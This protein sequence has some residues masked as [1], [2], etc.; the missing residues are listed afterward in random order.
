MRDSFSESSFKFSDF[1]ILNL[2][3]FFQNFLYL[4]KG[5]SLNYQSLNVLLSLA[6]LIL[7][8][9]NVVLQLYDFNVS[10]TFCPSSSDCPELHTL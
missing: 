5:S 9:A 7:Q 2:Y 1:F 6:E 10:I 4:L 8:L 3:F